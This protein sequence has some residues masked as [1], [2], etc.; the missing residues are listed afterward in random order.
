MAEN[1]TE[2]IDH[3]E[4]LEK[5]HHS[6]RKLGR[7]TIFLI[8]GL[9]GIWS[10]FA[11]IDTTITAQGKVITNSYNKIVMHPK[12]GIIKKVFVKDGDIV[13]AN[14]PLLKLDSTDYGSQLHSAISKYDASLFTICRLKA[15][16]TFNDAL[17]CMY[18]K[19][20]LLDKNNFGKL[21]TESEALFHSEMDNL[22]SKIALL[23]SQNEILIAQNK[24]LEQQQ[25]SQKKLLESYKKELKKWKK[26]LKSNA[27]DE[28]KA[29]ETERQIEQ[30][31]LTINSLSSKIEENLATINSNKKQ[32]D[33]EKASFK[34]TAM[35]KI[36][37]L[38]LDNKLTKDKIASFQNNLDNTLIKAP[39][40]GLVTD[41]KIH[42]AGE[43]VS[44]Q[45][46]I[47]SI[48]PDDKKLLIE[49]YVL[50]TDIDKVYAGQ[51][52]EISFPSFV[53]PSALPIEGELIYVSAD[54][55]IPE[56]FEEEF[57]KILVKITPKGM[58]AIKINKFEI[59]PGMPAS[60]FVRTGKMT[61][62][63]Y[64]MQPII[65]LSKGI[66]HAN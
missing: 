9:F 39:S 2:I 54:T 45:Q 17:S 47:M 40:K 28:L 1:N 61:L 57:Y 64:I 66:F 52:A 53:N 13:Q 11:K 51:K 26:L 8:F 36:S 56:G 23:K 44:P 16:A 12:G 48:V 35:E 38:E 42:T 25:E 50:P 18:I 29:I 37:E 33:L 63:Q 10:I 7:I 55:I 6:S 14:Q 20:E 62:M 31:K 24:G 59:L 15:Q 65:Q 21:Q 5:T 19:D 22:S 4:E 3:H 49:A 32:M 34:N 60:I 46:P 30:I 27:V 41:M 43:V 58:E